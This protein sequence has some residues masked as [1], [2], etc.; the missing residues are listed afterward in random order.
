LGIDTAFFNRAHS[1]PGQS[2][3][4][5]VE[6][7]P[8]CRRAERVRAEGSD[9]IH[10]GALILGSGVD[11]W[12]ANSLVTARLVNPGGQLVNSN[13]ETEESEEVI[14]TPILPKVSSAAL[15]PVL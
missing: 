4:I 9:R 6:R 8:C 1:V 5:K 11:P 14:E 7:A 12:Q 15:L 10:G 3:I 13:E 2:E